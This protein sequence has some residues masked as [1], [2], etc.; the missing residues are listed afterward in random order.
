MTRQAVLGLFIVAGLYVG[1]WAYFAPQHWYETFPGFGRNWLPQL[2]PYNQHLAKDAGA[3]YMALAVLSA[4]T[5]R[6][7]R[8]DPMVRTTGAVWLTFNVLHLVYHMQHLHMYG[9]TDQVL[10]V[11]VLSAQVLLATLL[12]LP[13]SPDTP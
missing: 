2:G 5:L 7:V 9:T 8:S 1:V 13:L 10:N 4:I 6:Y 3:T 11:A 12:L